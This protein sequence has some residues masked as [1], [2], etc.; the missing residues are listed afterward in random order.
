MAKSNTKTKVSLIILTLN[1]LKMTKEMLEN[2][3][4]LITSGIDATC[5]VV[6]NGSS[7]GSDRVL[8]NFN[9]PNMKFIYTKLSQNT[10]YAAGNNEGIKLALKNNADFVIILNNDIIMPN[11][12]LNSS[13]AFMQ[14]NPNFGAVS[15]KIYFS[16]GYEFHKDRYKKDELGKVI[17]YAGGNIDWDNIYTY[18]RGVDEVDC[19]QYNKPSETDV[20]NGACVIIRSKIFKSIGLLDES[21]FLYWEDSDYSMKIKK[22]GLK[23]GYYPGTHIW[24]KVSSSA[25][26]SG[27][28]TNDYFLTRNRYYFAL[29]YAKL[30]TKLAV[31][32]DTA[33]LALFGRTW[34]KKGAFDALI[35]TKGKGQWARK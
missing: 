4:K 14:D 1:S 11:E 9:L 19:G 31:V 8:R 27:G 3:S 5:I 30:R 23:V 24:H 34:Q 2:V 32:K 7:D 33:K 10:G 17:W 29:R 21:L 22:T 28:A 25:G 35:G 20:F 18:H 16:P 13:V 26:G 6:D 15:P 12:L